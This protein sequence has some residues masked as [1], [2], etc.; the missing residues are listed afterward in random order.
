[1]QIVIDVDEG[2]TKEEKLTV[3]RNAGKLLSR[4]DILVNKNQ[5]HTIEY[6]VYGFNGRFRGLLSIEF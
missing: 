1:M 5:D 4:R 2:L 3:V 6:S